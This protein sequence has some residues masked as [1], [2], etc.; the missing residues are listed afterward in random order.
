MTNTLAE[1]NKE[2]EKIEK[3]KNQLKKEL[4]QTKET[5][6]GLYPIQ[7]EYDTVDGIVWECDS[8]DRV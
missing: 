7:S 8:I 3:E 6:E 1:Q 2:F 5:L 4:K